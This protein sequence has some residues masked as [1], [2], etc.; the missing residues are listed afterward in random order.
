MRV[1]RGTYQHMYQD[2]VHIK[3][4][5]LK[6]KRVLQ[7]AETLNPFESSLKNGLLHQ[8]VHADESGEDD[9]GRTRNPGEEVVDLKRQMVLMKQ[10]MEEKDR[11]IQLMQLQMMKYERV[12]EDTGENGQ[13]A[14]MC[15]AATQTERIRPVSAGPSLLQSLPSDSNG[16]PLVSFRIGKA[17]GLD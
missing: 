17:Y 16:V 13:P 5:L 15:N 2:V 9:D 7:E 6:L 3:T 8:L 10:Q 1:D 4:M 12:S 14:D 11:T